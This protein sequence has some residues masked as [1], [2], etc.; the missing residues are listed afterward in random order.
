LLN[1]FPSIMNVPSANWCSRQGCAY[2]AEV[3]KIHCCNACRKNEA[4]HTQHCTHLYAS[5][6]RL[7]QYAAPPR[8]QR[9]PNGHF[10]DVLMPM[11]T[12]TASYM[13]DLQ[14]YHKETNYELEHDGDQLSA[15]ATFFLFVKAN[16][17]KHRLGD[18]LTLRAVQKVHAVN[19]KADEL[20][21]DAT[22]L[23]AYPCQ[24]DSYILRHVIGSDWRVQARVLSSPSSPYFFL[25]AVASIEERIHA[26]HDSGGDPFSGII[27]IFCDHG[28]HRSVAAVCLLQRWVYPEAWTERLVP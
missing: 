25:K 27:N 12:A 14:W 16:K 7:Q 4:H 6:T 5:A 28:R 26:N 21:I 11:A 3:R 9:L 2:Y 22:K 23:S 20:S 13:K 18:T 10:E 19:A 24:N 17:A 1:G 8:F 15:W